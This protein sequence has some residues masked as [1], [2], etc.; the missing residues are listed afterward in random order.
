MHDLIH[1][2]LVIEFFA[3]GLFPGLA[4]RGV[5]KSFQTVGI[6]QCIQPVI[7]NLYP[8][9]ERTVRRPDM[10]SDGAR[11][12]NFIP[13]GAE[14]HQA[15]TGPHARVFTDPPPVT[16]VKLRLM[17][18]TAMMLTKVENTFWLI[19]L[20]LKTERRGII[21]KFQILRLPTVRTGHVK[22]HEM[23]RLVSGFFDL[24]GAFDFRRRAANGFWPYRALDTFIPQQGW[25]PLFFDIRLERGKFVIADHVHG[26]FTV[27]FGGSAAQAPETD[28]R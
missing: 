18:H 26:F 28:A 2:Y 3:H 19:L 5:N 12:R 21:A 17:D 10:E 16:L 20:P 14:K 13:P 22:T 15:V 6:F 23:C 7:D 27:V 1:Q 9:G 4:Q 25:R 11:R 8:G 24:A